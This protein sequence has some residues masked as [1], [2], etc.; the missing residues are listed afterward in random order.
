MTYE[1]IAVLILTAM[2]GFCLGWALSEYRHAGR[3][4]RQVRKDFE[5]TK[6]RFSA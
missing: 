4:L 1:I 3:E 6:Q 2:E 5:D